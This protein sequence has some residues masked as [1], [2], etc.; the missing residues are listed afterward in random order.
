MKVKN[1]FQAFAFKCNVYRYTLVTAALTTLVSGLEAR[2]ELV[3]GI[4]KIS[5]VGRY[6][7]NSGAPLSCPLA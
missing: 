7:L 4:T 2:T 5:W 3:T 6:K 1:R